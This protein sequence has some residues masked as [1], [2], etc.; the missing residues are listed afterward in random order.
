MD[1]ALLHPSFLN[2]CHDDSTI[3][4]ATQHD[5]SMASSAPV[6]LQ[7][8]NAPHSTPFLPPRPTSTYATQRQ[9]RISQTTFQCPSIHLVFTKLIYL[10]PEFETFSCTTHIV[11]CSFCSIHADCCSG[12]ICERAKFHHSTRY[13]AIQTQIDNTTTG[14]YL[15]RLLPCA[16]DEHWNADVSRYAGKLQLPPSKLQSTTA[17]PPK[18]SHFLT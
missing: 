10:G 14:K 1:T 7:K 6:R 11:S 12:S 15:H 8:W 18:Q 4:A 3:Q 16:T 17:Q 2:A 5:L 13:S 9:L